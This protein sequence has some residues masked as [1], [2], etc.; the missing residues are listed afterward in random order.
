LALV[1][2]DT[3]Y[4]SGMKHLPKI[5]KE[6]C[7]DCHWDFG[8]KGHPNVTGPLKSEDLENIPKVSNTRLHKIH[9]A[10]KTETPLPNN[11][12]LDTSLEEQRR[13]IAE[14]EKKVA[15]RDIICADC[16]GGIPN[17]AH[18]FGATDASCIRCHQKG[19]TEEDVHC[20]SPTQKTFGC[21]NC[22]FLEFMAETSGSIFH[23][24]K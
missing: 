15:A 24:S 8:H 11:L 19:C 21:R 14:P 6:L 22:H 10:K 9:L 3:G 1:K 12:H 2:G 13:L 5:S 4:P 18:N 23:E 20:F 17:R 7:Q 16:H